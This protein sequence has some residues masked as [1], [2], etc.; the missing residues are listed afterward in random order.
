VAGGMIDLVGV[1]RG[2]K[3]REEEINGRTKKP[4]KEK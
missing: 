2:E 3:E 1:K 4:L